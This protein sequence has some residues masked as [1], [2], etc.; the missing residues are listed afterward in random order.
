MIQFNPWTG[1]SKKCLGWKRSAKKTNNKQAFGASKSSPYR[2]NRRGS[3]QPAEG[4]FA[5]CPNSTIS[6]PVI[7]F[8][9]RIATCAVLLAGGSHLTSGSLQITASNFRVSAVKS[10]CVWHVMS[11]MHYNMLKQITQGNA[12]KCIAL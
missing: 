6:L 11:P 9:K 3:S 4:E 2:A 12:I 1:G 10:A 8:Q 7:F 5:F